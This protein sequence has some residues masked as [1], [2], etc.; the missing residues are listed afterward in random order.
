MD[1]ENLALAAVAIVVTAV[2]IVGTVVTL[3]QEGGP[4]ALFFPILIAVV[5]YAS[6]KDKD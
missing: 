4:G 6:S 2:T 5:V 3:V 1:K